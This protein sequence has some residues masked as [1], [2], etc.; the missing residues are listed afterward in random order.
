MKHQYDLVAL[1]LSFLAVTPAASQAQV[2]PSTFE[3][4]AGPVRV[5]PLSAGASIGTRFL[6][7]HED[8][9]PGLIQ[10]IGFR[11]L[12]AVG[13]ALPART[14]MITVRM[15]HATSTATS[16]DSMFQANHGPDVRTVFGPMAVTFGPIPAVATAPL[17]FT[18]VITLTSSFYYDGVSPLCWDID[19]FDVMGSTPRGLYEGFRSPDMNPRPREALLL[20]GCL[21][22]TSTGLPFEL[23]TAHQVDWMQQSV[24]SYSLSNGPPR[25]TAFF[26]FGLGAPIG[27][28]LPTTAAGPSGVCTLELASFIPLGTVLDDMGAASTSFSVTLPTS[29]HGATLLAQG[30]AVDQLAN[31][32]GLV[33]S[34]ANALHLIAPFSLLQVGTVTGHPTFPQGVATAGAGAVVEFQ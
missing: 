8:L 32:L 2:S 27:F 29:L 5:T 14:V 4:S 3:T 16:P 24:L 15:S 31:P 23:S 20:T 21:P 34:H 6:Q 12:G 25:Q 17:P 10:S 30:A 7:I 9:P 28:P 1:L 33:T 19:S 11:R 13:S 18:D 26:L 22:S